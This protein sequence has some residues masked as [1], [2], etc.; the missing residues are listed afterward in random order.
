MKPQIGSDNPFVLFLSLFL[1]LPLFLSLSLFLS[2][3]LSLSLSL[4][5]SSSLSLFNFHSLCFFLS[6]LFLPISFSCLPLCRSLSCRSLSLSSRISILYVFHNRLVS[7]NH[8]A[9][10][11]RS[12]I[13]TLKLNHTLQFNSSSLNSRP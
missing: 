2:F 6:S 3:S 8:F 9:P 13:L 7:V 1:S 5:L 11:H 4:S 10:V 12:F